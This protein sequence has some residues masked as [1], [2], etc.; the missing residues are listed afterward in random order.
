MWPSESWLSNP[1][2]TEEFC[3][4][5]VIWVTDDHVFDFKSGAHRTDARVF[6][7][8]ISRWRCNGTP[9]QNGLV[10]CIQASQNIIVLLR[11]SCRCLAWKALFDSCFWQH[12]FWCVESRF[13]P[14]RNPDYWCLSALVTVNLHTFKV[15]GR[16][17]KGWTK[18]KLLSFQ[19]SLGC[20]SV[21]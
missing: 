11:H 12:P 5:F 1:S 14:Y 2:N 16:V 21:I 15:C 13:L 19:V 9:W 4:A 10:V 17:R 20:K 6:S 7:L 3:Q 8:R 18:L